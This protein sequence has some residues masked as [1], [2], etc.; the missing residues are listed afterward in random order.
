M[1]RIINDKGLSKIKNW[2]ECVL[3]TYD[4]ADT[5]TPKKR[6]MPGDK[7]KGTLTFGWGHTSAAGM[8]KVTPGMTITQE[9]ANSILF[10]DLIFPCRRVENLVM[11]PLSDNQ[12]AALVSFE[13]NTGSLGSS[14]LLKKLNAGEYD[15]VPSEMM[16]W[17]KTTVNGKKVKSSGLVNRRAAEAGLWASGSTIASASSEAMPSTPPMLNKESLSWG[18]GILASLGA[19]MQGNGPV[20]W[21]LGAVIAVSFITS[22]GFF[23]YKRRAA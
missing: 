19:I 16:R 18:A 9:E 23:L 7:V 21:A 17:V 1:V 13:L 5:F 8:P 22:L 2:E 11:V 6:I 4:D 14:T 12:F 15:A 3:Y 10:K 20:Q